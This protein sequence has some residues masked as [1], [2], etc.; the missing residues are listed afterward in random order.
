[1]IRHLT[2]LTV[3][4]A[5]WGPFFS[6]IP[7]SRALVN[8]VRLITTPRGYYPISDGSAYKNRAK[9]YKPSRIMGNGTGPLK[10]G[11]GVLM[12]EMSMTH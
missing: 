7:D 9:A 4:R 3:T 10:N 11:H 2:V 8:G 1:M 12:R 5:E 6:R